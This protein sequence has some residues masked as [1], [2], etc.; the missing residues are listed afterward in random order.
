M[1]VMLRPD[2]L[3]LTAL[4]ALL[5]AAGP[6][7]TDLYVPSLPEIGRVFGASTSQVQLTISAYLIGFAAGQIIYGPI[8]DRHGRKPVLLAASG[9]YA[10]AGAACALA[11]TIEALI[12]ARVLQAVGGCG[13][14]VVARAVVRDLYQGA[15]AGRE[16]SLMAAI[17][18][19]VPIIAPAA[20]GVVQAAGWRAVFAV[21]VLFGV[22]AAVL[23]ARWLPETL[24][25][26][27]TE[28]ISLA[29][30]VRSYRTLLR[31][32]AFLIPTGYV[33]F[34]YGGL[35]AWISGAAFVLQNNHGLTPLTF[36]LAFAFGSAGYMVGTFLAAHLVTRLGLDRTIGLGASVLAA[37]GLLM[38]GSVALHAASVTTLVLSMALYLG[39][40]GLVLPQAT[41]AALSP[42]PD[43][44]GAASSLL[45]VTQ[46]L[47]AA[48]V[49]TMVGHLLGDTAWPMAVA[50]S[51]MGVLTL[52]LWTLSRRGGG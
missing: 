33:A 44:A 8:S 1:V 14:V 7:A 45:G 28:P 29:S 4:L 42:F 34:S 38:L 37:G 18:A 16:L 30:I 25:R 47:C 22:A 13:L 26:R 21:P 9:L 40:L 41:A 24:K 43:R 23:V 31:D 50:V 19:L 11:P 36:G 27:A 12:A 39:G 20:G 32:R 49:G 48:L 6:I 3:A 17:M 46:Q 52:A 10:V 35:F 5:T 51:L 2:T 15:R